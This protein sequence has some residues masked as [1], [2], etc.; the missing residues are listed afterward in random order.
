MRTLL[1]ALSLVGLLA[2]T[3]GADDPKTAKQDPTKKEKGAKLQVGDAAP[4]LKASK[5]LQGDRVTSF[6]SGKVYVVEFWATWCGPC[7]VMMP[8]LSELQAEYKN[9]GV[10]IIGFSSKD[11]N[12]SETKVTDFVKKRGEKLKYTFAYADDRE[13]NNAWM[14][15][16]GRNGIPCTFVVDKASKIA[17]IGHPM[18]LDVVLPKVVDGS[19]KGKESAEDIANTVEK[20]V[21]AVFTAQ[22]GTD[23]EKKLKAITDFQ[24]RNPALADI[25]YFIAPKLNLLVETRKLVEAKKAAKGL[26]EKAVKQDNQLVMR[27]VSAAMRTGAAKED[28]A[29]L[30]LS[31]KAAEALLQSAGD[32]EPMALL[33]MAE[34]HMATGDKDKAKELC[35]KAVAAADT[36]AIKKS[37][38]ASVKRLLGD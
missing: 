5:W 26:L 17:Y 25:P 14:Q 11:P 20:E 3:A 22:R 4:A 24:A 30:A 16:A 23:A 12:N 7:I 33:T 9:K 6:E 27:T 35:E 21:S 31:L 37:V 19:W 2:L 18:F 32:K 28:K 8:H 15:A 34:V 38:Q 1:V 10:T 13:T 29:S 36:P